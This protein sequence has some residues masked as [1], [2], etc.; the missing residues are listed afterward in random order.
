MNEWLTTKMKG[1]ARTTY[2]RF[3][4]NRGVLRNLPIAE[5]AKLPGCKISAR[6][7]RT[8]VQEVNNGRQLTP[9]QVAGH[10][11][12]PKMNHKRGHV[13][14]RSDKR[15]DAMFEFSTKRRLV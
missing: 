8:L 13:D 12:L 2:I 7:I 6:R 15:N 4:D 5:I 11:D 1:H 10:D 3:I 9:R 14:Y